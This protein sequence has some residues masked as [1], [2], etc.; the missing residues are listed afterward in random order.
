M[1]EIKINNPDK[2]FTFIVTNSGYEGNGELYFKGKLI[3]SLTGPGYSLD[4]YYLIDGYKLNDYY[5]IDDEYFT[6]PDYDP[7]IENYITR[8]PDRIYPLVNKKYIDIRSSMNEIKINTPGKPFTFIENPNDIGWGKLYFR[9][10]IVDNNTSKSDRTPGYYM[11]ARNYSKNSNYDPDIEKYISKIKNALHPLIDEKY[12]DIKSSIGEIKVEIPGKPFTFIGKPDDMGWG[13]LYF[14]DKLI[15]PDTSIKKSFQIKYGEFEEKNDHYMVNGKGEYFTSPDYDPSIESYITKNPENRYDEV[16]EKYVLIKSSPIEE[17][18]INIPGKPFTFVEKDDDEGWGRL[19][20]RDKLIDNNTTTS[21]QN[22]GYYMLATK[23]FPYTDYFNSPDYDP[24]IEKFIFEDKISLYYLIDEKYVDIKSSINE[25]K[26]NPAGKPFKFIESQRSEWGKLYY[27]EH[28][29]DESTFTISKNQSKGL[30]NETSAMTY[31]KTIREYNLERY[32]IPQEMTNHIFNVPEDNQYYALISGKYIEF[33]PF[34]LEEIKVK[35]PGKPFRFDWKKTDQYYRG[36]G[37]LYFKDK[38]IDSDT[39]IDSRYNSFMIENDYFES[40]DYDPS[41]ENYIFR[42]DNPRDFPMVER[43]Y[44]MDDSIPY[45][46]HEIK[47]KSPDKPFIFKNISKGLRDST[48]GSLYFKDQLIDEDSVADKNHIMVYMDPSLYMNL[49]EELEP[50]LNSGA[51]KALTL[52]GK[53]IIFSIKDSYV[54]FE[55]PINEIKVEK[56]KLNF[57]FPFTIKD[58]S[59]IPYIVQ[60]LNDQGYTYKTHKFKEEDLSFNIPSI[61]HYDSN[62]DPE[63]KIL[64][65]FS[66]MEE[67]KVVTPGKPLRFAVTNKIGNVL[68][69]SVYFKDVLLDDNAA[70]LD[71]EDRPIHVSIAPDLFNKIKYEFPEDLVEQFRS[72]VKGDFYKASLDYSKYFG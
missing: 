15:D 52:T 10:N 28:L 42:T 66:S 9:N 17:I 72:W 70:K 71:E 3:D 21:T 25:I 23:I 22:P 60:Q 44:V 30:I 18:K 4:D 16:D 5:L 50:Y 26:I 62:Y 8:D 35:L 36:W 47:V 31:W 53:K 45:G 14:K 33:I 6:S 43:I 54:R 49:A 38:L 37:E 55:T 41:I 61:L 56:P 24:E 32:I 13:K 46:V 59:Q 7:S 29:L 11:L 19:Y 27:Y 58:R 40:K 2:P 20:F 67:I 57:T 39:G 1:N 64:N 51:E 69:G 34:P 63:R 48:V 12:V 65:T 68:K